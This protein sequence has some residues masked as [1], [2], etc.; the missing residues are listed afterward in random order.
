MASASG[1]MGSYFFVEKKKKAKEDLK[2]TETQNNQ[3]EFN[4]SKT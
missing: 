3:N 4:E 2:C 1:P